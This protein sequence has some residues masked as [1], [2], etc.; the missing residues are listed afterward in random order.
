MIRV[1][2]AMRINKTKVK[3]ILKGEQ[4]NGEIYE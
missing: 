3:S 1:L 4:R 2:Y